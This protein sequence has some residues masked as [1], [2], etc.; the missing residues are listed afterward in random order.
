MCISDFI[1]KCC[2]RKAFT[3]S[4]IQY[5]EYL[6]E[7]WYTATALENSKV[8]FSI[9]SGGIHGVLGVNT[10]RKDIGA[11]YLAMS[12]DYAD[13]PSIEIVRPWFAIIR[14]GKDMPAKGPPF[15]AHML[16]ICEADKAVPFKATKT[17]SKV[18]KQVSIGTKPGAKTRHKKQSIYFKQPSVSSKE[19]TKSG[20]IERPTGSKTSHSEKRKESSSAKYSNPIHPP[21]STPIDTG[22]HKED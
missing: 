10:F 19:E 4:P 11:N 7:F 1:S 18:K 13:P 20:S 14:Y 6:S 5:K 12:S 2:L 3:R 8:Y 22:M 16:A 17:S 15:T 21:V 9:R